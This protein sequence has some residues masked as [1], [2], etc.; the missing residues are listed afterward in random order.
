M[1]KEEEEEVVFDLPEDVLVKILCRLP[2]KSLIRFTCV[3]KR[4]RSLIIS[5]SQFARFTFEV[6]SQTRTL[7]PRLLLCT[8]P[9]TRGYCPRFEWEPSRFECLGDLD[10]PCFWGNSPVHRPRFVWEPSRLTVPPEVGIERVIASCNGLVV[11]GNV[12]RSYTNLSVWNPSTGFFRKI[13]SPEF[14]LEKGRCISSATCGFGHVMATDYYKLVFFE[15][16]DFAVHIFSTNDSSWRVFRAPHLSFPHYYG[17]ALLVSNGAIHWVSRTGI[18]E[19]AISAF[20]L[21]DEKFRQLPLP[22]VMIENEDMNARPIGTQVL[23][24]GH[25]CVWSNGEFWVMKEYAVPES[26]VKM[27]QFSVLDLPDVFAST[28]GW[29]PVFVT[30]GGTVVILLD[31][32]L[33]RIECHRERKPVCSGR[34]KIEGAMQGLFQYAATVYDETLLSV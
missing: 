24:G 33:V 13:P 3:S 22:R 32:E 25:L 1:S 9:Y 8:Y 21:A 19:P 7:R 31:K 30:Q 29:I 17:R 27:F 26:W 10:M 4:W 6:A 20:D 2:V 14:L 23:K 16:L 5:D 11:L 28:S 12:Y 18:G 34:Y 15:P